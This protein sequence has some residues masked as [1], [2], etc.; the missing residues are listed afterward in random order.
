VTRYLETLAECPELAEQMGAS[1]RAFAGKYF[2]RDNCM[3]AFERELLI[4]TGRAC[5]QVAPIAGA[6]M[7]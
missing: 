7:G 2:A 5:E 6:V 4:A 3:A 1:G